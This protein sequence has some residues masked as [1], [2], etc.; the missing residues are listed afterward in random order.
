MT[1]RTYLM[2]IFFAFIT[3]VVY[4]FVSARPIPPETALVPR[5]LRSLESDY[6]FYFTG[7]TGMET[8]GESA[9]QPPPQTA[10]ETRDESL[11]FHLG[12]RFGYVGKD[13]VLFSTGRTGK[14]HI[15]AGA[16]FWTVWED[17]ADTIEIRN[18]QGAEEVHIPG[19]AGWPFFVDGRFFL[20]GEELDYLS[21]LD[22]SGAAEWTYDF[23]APLTDLDAAAGLVLAGFLD[24]A[25]EILDQAGKRIFR[26][27]PGGSRFSVIYRC[28]ISRDGSRIAIISGYDDQRFLL[29]EKS[30]NTWK[31]VYHEFLSG[32]FRRAVHL[33]FVDEGRRVVFE[34]EG[35][36]GIYDIAARKLHRLDL[37]G[38]LYA[39]EEYGGEAI[40]FAI[41]S[42]SETRRKLVGISYPS[43]IILEA[44]FRSESAFLGREEERLYLGGGKVLAAFSLERR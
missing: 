20:I 2:G 13:G 3:F 31:V 29:L 27:E 19:T 5:W 6:S 40:L 42:Q 21:S 33:A 9:D 14:A 15:A 38:R 10:G 8:G 35:G 28:R 1:K 4:F 36:I 39:L 30:G 23:A 44:P 34:R 16:G 37:D 18:E 11:L 7:V 41:T 12:D 17:G 25:V 22:R 32:G 26:F 24:G 43:S